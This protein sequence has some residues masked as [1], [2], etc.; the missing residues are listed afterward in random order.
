MPDINYRN[1][2]ASEHMTRLSRWW[3]RPRNIGAN[4]DP[5]LRELDGMGADGFRLDAVRHLIEDGQVQENT[6]ETHAWLKSFRA[7]CKQENPDALLIGE[8]WAPTEIAAS[9]IGDELDMTFEFDLA[10]AMVEAAKSGTAA[11]L[12]AAQA[13]TLKSFPPNQYGRFLTNHDQSRVMTQLKGD[14]GAARAAAA[15]LLTG[16]GVPFIYYG[17]EIGMTGDKPDPD[18]RTPMQWSGGD[19]GGGEGD[20]TAGFS[21]A[22]PW[23]A[24]NPDAKTVNVDSERDDPGSLFN[25]YRGLLRLRQDIPALRHG[26]AVPVECDHPGIYAILRA[27]G[28]GERSALVVVNLTDKPVTEYRLACA[29]AASFRGEPAELLRR[30]HPE[31][32]AIDPDG[33][34]REYCPLKILA[35]HQGYVIVNDV[36]Q[37]MEDRQR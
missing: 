36:S 27:G 34:F 33:K 2:A 13:R 8:V 12:I 3:L 9:Y 18:I 22:N 28:P 26:G 1:A 4:H 11:P 15:L 32:A 6:P 31:H 14:P 37:T 29:E 24:V 35:P 21:T 7:A 17:E 30:C 19:G 10:A 5:K 23:R 25:L 16:P 20:K